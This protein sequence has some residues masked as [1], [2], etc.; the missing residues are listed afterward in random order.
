MLDIVDRERGDKLQSLSALIGNTPM[1]KILARYQGQEVTVYAKAEM[2]NLSGSIKDRMALA[3]LQ[4]AIRRGD[5]QPGQTIVEATSGNSGISFAAIGSALG[6]PVTIF[7]PDWVSAER[8]ALLAVYGA[9]VRLVSR[10]DGGFLGCMAA[11]EHCARQGAYLPRQFS[12]PVN[13]DEHAQG[14][15]PEIWRQVAT[16]GAALGGFV[17]GVGTGG[18]VMGIGRYLKDRDAGIRVHPVEPLESPTLSVGHKCGQHRVQGL[19]DE[20]IPALLDLSELDGVIGVHDGDA[21][22]MAQQLLRQ[23]GLGVGISSGIN[24]VAAIRLAL[25][26][27]AAADGTRKAVATIF[28]DSNSKYLS[29]DLAKD[30]PCRDGYWTPQMELLDIETIR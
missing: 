6:H 19:S 20:F 9:D 29:T 28:A 2:Y 14:T 7:M 23:F 12:N 1:I 17:A 5:L 11:A 16:D 8:R 25:E 18:T 24:L 15:G 13:A 3:I 30:E 21:I 27:P 10:A 4:D 26:Q 22:L